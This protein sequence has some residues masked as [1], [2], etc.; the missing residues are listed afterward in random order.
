MNPI[1]ITESLQHTMTQYLL[2]TFDVNRDGQEPELKNALRDSFNTDGALFNGPFLEMTLPYVV[3]SSLREI[4]DQGV[5]SKDLIDLECF[6]HDK[7]IG[8]DVKLYKHQ[9]AALRKLIEEEKNLIVSSGTGSGKTECFLIP[10]LNDLILDPT[11]GVR[12][13]I[14]YPLNALVNDQLSRL[15]ELLEG[16]DITFGKYTGELKDHFNDAVREFDGDPLPNEIICRDQIRY[17]GKIPQILITNYAMLEY[18]LLRPVDAPL[19]NSGKWKYI[20][21]DEAHT[22]AGTQGIEIG[23]LVRRLRHRLNLSPSD[24]QCVATSATLTTDDA[25]KAAKFGE[26]LFGVPFDQE[27]V[28]F[29]EVVKE[30]FGD[31]HFTDNSAECFIDPAFSSLI[32]I[33]RKEELSTE[34]LALRMAEMGFN[35]QR[36]FIP[37]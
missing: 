12:A 29:G 27:D 18:L 15:R 3:T 25:E 16:T 23:H 33:V 21:L 36:A 6:N 31:D 2:T 7:P 30:V 11:P 10:I 34:D 5:I 13:V 28:I 1:Q 37:C 32:E 35:D 9:E 26:K 24:M 4:C 8:L 19:F 17:E 22:Y 20:V 14:I